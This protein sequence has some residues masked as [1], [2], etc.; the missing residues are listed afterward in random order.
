MDD[1]ATIEDFIEYLQEFNPKARIVNQLTL[2]WSSKDEDSAVF[3]SELIHKNEAKFVSVW[4]G[5]MKLDQNVLKCKY[6][7]VCKE[8]EQLKQ[9]NDNQY[10]QLNELWQL[11]EAKDWETL[12]AM[13]KKMKED[14]ERLRNEWKCYE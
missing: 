14:E 11:I 4:S 2:S 1:R 8:N 3:E 5:F 9:R 6:E 7:K 10:N 13:D 12:T